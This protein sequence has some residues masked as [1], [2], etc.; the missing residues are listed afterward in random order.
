MVN[1]KPS[2]HSLGRTCH[3]Y[4]LCFVHAYYLFQFLFPSLALSKTKLAKSF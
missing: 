1:V 4:T 2:K 3:R